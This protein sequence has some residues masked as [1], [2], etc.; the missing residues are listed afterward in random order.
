[1]CRKISNL[2]LSDVFLQTSNAPKPAFGW[3]FASGGFRLGPGAP[4]FL[5]GSIVIS[6]SRC[7]LPNDEGPARKYFFLEPPLDSAPDPV[8]GA[9]DAPSDPLLGWGGG[10]PHT[11]PPQRFWLLNFYLSSR[12]KPTGRSGGAFDAPSDPLVGCR[13]DPPYCSLRLA[14]RSWRL[15]CLRRLNS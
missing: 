6:L 15:C 8:G 14:S 9:C 3:D 2:S 4:K 1:M 7:C 11:V 12:G 10:Y 13:G 5:I